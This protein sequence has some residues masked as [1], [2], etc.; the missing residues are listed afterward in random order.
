MRRLP[1]QL[2]YQNNKE[3]SSSLLLV[4]Q[5][6]PVHLVE[7]VALR[8]TQTTIPLGPQVGADLVNCNFFCLFLFFNY[9]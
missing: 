5:T 3:R 4:A 8:L 2:I 7:L 1:V 6:I 9:L